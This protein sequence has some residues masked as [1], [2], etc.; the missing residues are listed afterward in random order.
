MAKLVR[1]CKKAETADARQYAHNL[2]VEL[3]KE[4]KKI[5]SKIK[6]VIGE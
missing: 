3:S 5:N 2:I 4:M 6:I 1:Q